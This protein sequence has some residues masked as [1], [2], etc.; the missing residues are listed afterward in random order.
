MRFCK[1]FLKEVL[2]VPS[3]SC[4]EERMREYI[5]DFAAK[6]NMVSRRDAKGNLYVTKGV[7]DKGEYCPCLIEHMDTVQSWQLE[8][9]TSNKR[10]R[11]LE[12]TVKDGR[13]K[14][15]VQKGGIGADDKAGIAIALALMDS[16]EK[17]KAVFCVEEEVGL[18]GSS[19]MDYDFLADVS[20]CVTLDAPECLVSAT[21]GDRVRR[22]MYNQAFFNSILKPVCDKYGMRFFT[23]RAN[24][25]IC[26]VMKNTDLVCWDL[27]NGGYKPHSHEEYVVFEDAKISYNL[28]RDLFKTLDKRQ[29][30]VMPKGCRYESI[31]HNGQEFACLCWG[32]I[33]V[34]V[35]R[36]GSRKEVLDSMSFL[37]GAAVELNKNGSYFAMKDGVRFE[38]EVVEMPGRDPYD[39]ISLREAVQGYRDENERL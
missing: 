34:D 24:T 30:Y 19:A 17:C 27:C 7:Q 36:K 33:I 2:S 23:H 10:I 39:R 38:F 15:Y 26:N 6:H 12:K 5:V 37:L 14:L 31:N 4:H 29:R 16:M 3:V 18:R 20:F 8:Y 9:V 28:L 25:D 13:T 22:N 35:L 11:I 32:G 1:T 21:R